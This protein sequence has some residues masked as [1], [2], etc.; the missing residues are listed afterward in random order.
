MK[1]E[2]GQMLTP[3]QLVASAMNYP[4]L[5]IT[6]NETRE[7]RLAWDGEAK[8]NE[9]RVRGREEHE[10]SAELAGFT[11]AELLIKQ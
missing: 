11:R 2:R 6:G 7:G 5:G 8:K 9:M 10:V 1:N 4:E 3:P